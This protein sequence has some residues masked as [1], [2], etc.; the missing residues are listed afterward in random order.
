MTNEVSEKV[1]VECSKTL[2]EISDSEV[3]GSPPMRGDGK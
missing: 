1:A 3:S 2:G